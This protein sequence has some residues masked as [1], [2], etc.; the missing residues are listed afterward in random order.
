[1]K[2]M[3]F[4]TVL[5]ILSILLIW[6]AAV[7]PA[8]FATVYAA[9]PA[10]AEPG[11][12]I[13]IGLTLPDQT[14]NTVFKS[15]KAN[16]DVLSEELPVTFLYSDDGNADTVVKV[17][18]LIRKNVDGIMISRMEEKE[19]PIICGMC[20]E[21]EVYWGLFLW[22]ILD[23]DIR[24]FCEA[25]EYYAGNTYEDEESAGRLMLEK[26]CEKG[27]RK[28]A[29][30]SE[31]EWH[32]T[33]RKREIGIH[34]AAKQHP[35]VSILETVRSLTDREDAG[36]VAENLICAYPELDCII[37]VGSIAPEAEEG[38][39][40]GIRNADS[41]DKVGL[42]T[43]DFSENTP[44]NLE[45]GIL[46]GSY[47]L[48]QLSTDPYYLALI[49]INRIYGTPIGEP[50]VS[51]CIRGTFVD[52]PEKARLLENVILDDDLI[53]Y[54][55]EE[56]HRLFKWENPDLDGQ[57]LQELSDRLQESLSGEG[58]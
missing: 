21:A 1:M 8:T 47:G 6:S 22:D 37:L 11:D 26:A 14:E 12:E 58:A 2:K 4:L 55:N 20:E 39:L 23:D 40:D 41:E 32:S 16:F 27:F 43:F 51:C 5:R 54:Q 24:S 31:S 25:S 7:P 28:I 42:M 52:S 17:E 36:L 57:E 48:L 33:C 15:M 10:A 13:V 45:E 38:I 50:R 3:P 29:L 30:I 35:D 46:R 19:L 9:V 56:L 49:L 34:G 44:G 18:E 53:Y